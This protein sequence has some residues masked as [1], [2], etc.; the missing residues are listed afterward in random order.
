MSS[1]AESSSPEPV[2]QAE[3]PKPKPWFW[4]VFIVVFLG[5]FS[6]RMILAHRLSMPPV[7]AELPT[8]KLTNE[9]GQPF[10]TENLRGKTYIANFVFTS[11][12]SV[13]PKLTK[14]MSEV[15]ERTKDLGDA[16]HLVTFSVDPENDTP[17]ILKGY[18]QKYSADP[19]RWVFLTGPLKEIEP[20]IMQGF[21]TMVAKKE[22]PSGMFEI[23]HGERFV[24]V[25]GKGFIRGFYE[26]T[27]EGTDGLINDARKIAK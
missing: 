19:A 23:V 20:V 27:A 8:Y 21:K 22:A 1:A 26:A 3:K 11:C 5:I 4:V 13:C 10:G 6:A 14:R 12:P 24:L 16:L 9:Q 17:E 7:V 2:T 25:D 15:Q 18:A